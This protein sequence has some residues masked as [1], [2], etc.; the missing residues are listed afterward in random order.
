MADH[1]PGQ[2]RIGGKIP[3]SLAP[4]LCREI[5]NAYVSLE[6]GDPAFCPNSAADLMAARREVDGVLLL[7]LC[8]DQARFGEFEELEAFLQ[9]HGIA[10]T[11]QSD[12]KYE[13]DGELLEYRPGSEPDLFTTNAVGQPVVPAS[14]LSEVEAALTE[15]LEQLAKG[16]GCEG[17]A[18]EPA[19]RARQLLREQ[20]PPPVPPLEPFE[21]D[22]GESPEGN[23]G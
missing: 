22:T 5:G 12:P 17:A 11:R 10:Y 21:I 6:W 20:L 7:E 2:I 15:T 19:Q 16:P 3:Q 8:D 4:E 18:I 1:M 13:H 23:H 9:E 14:A